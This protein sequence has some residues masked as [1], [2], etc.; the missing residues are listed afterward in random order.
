MISFIDKNGEPRVMTN[1]YFI[2]ELKSN[3]I[4]LGQVTES[5]CDIRMKEDYL[6]MHDQEGKLLVKANRSQNRLYK[7]RMGIKETARLFLTTTSDS[8]RWH[9]WLGHVNLETIRNMIQKELVDGIPRIS[10]E[11]E[12]CSS[13]LLGKQTR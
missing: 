5:G 12:I 4:S 3:I 13:C 2:P 10:I 6:T 8:S 7:V 9:A 1:V 11:K